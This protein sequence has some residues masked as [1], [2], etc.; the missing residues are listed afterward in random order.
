MAR[1]VGGKNPICRCSTKSSKQL[2]VYDRRAIRM[3]TILAPDNPELIK[4]YVNALIDRLNS[5]EKNQSFED[6]QDIL[7][8][9]T[10]LYPE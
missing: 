10:D 3:L 5:T 4:P 2:S 8:L 1:M 7:T 9:I 6:I